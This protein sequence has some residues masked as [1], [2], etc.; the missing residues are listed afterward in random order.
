MARPRRQT[1][2]YFF[3]YCRGGKT[4]FILEGKYGNDGYAFWF[5]LL[6]LLGETEGHYYDCSKAT[7]W[8]F[9]LAK[10]HLT[11][12]VAESIIG[13]LVDLGK[14]DGELW[15]EKRVLWVERFVNYLG[16]LYR[17]RRE[18]VP[19]RPYAESFCMQKSSNEKVSD[20]ETHFPDEKTAVSDAEIHDHD[21]KATVSDAETPQRRV[22]KS[23]EGKEGEER[24]EAVVSLWN[25]TL[26]DLLPKVAVLSEG[27]RQ[28]ISARLAEISPDSDE[29]LQQVQA[30]FDKVRASRFL[31]GDN[32][33]NWTITIDW[34]FHSS[35]N[36]AK[37]LEGNYD[38]KRGI[39]SQATHPGIT[40][41]ADERIE[42]DGRRTY[43]TGVATV[44]PEAPPRPSARHQWDAN[45]LRWMFI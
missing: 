12:E 22:E 42:T 17:K 10:T 27:R 30:L 31:L 19:S 3:H 6:E 14:V 33:R 41:G 15:R 11:G 43:G 40:L 9:L 1:V 37:V 26:G 38:D 29:A 4:L 13:T 21:A 2:E 25:S 24:E 39:R 18:D 8:E 7:N 28:Q 32:D 35:E 23:R 45:A 36:I 44:P 5:K 16:D 34:L 20:A